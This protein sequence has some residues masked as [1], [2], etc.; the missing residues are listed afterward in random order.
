MTNEYVFTIIAL[1]N[2]DGEMSLKKQQMFGGSP[3]KVVLNLVATSE[4][5]ALKEAKGII[6]RKEY[7]VSG[8]A[9]IREPDTIK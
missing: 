9:R 6:K 7:I 2:D 5:E 8:V 3:S 1:D 4:K